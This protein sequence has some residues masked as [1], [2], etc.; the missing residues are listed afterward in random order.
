MKPRDWLFWLV[1]AI[2][3]GTVAAGLAQL[4]VPHVVLDLVGGSTMNDAAYFFAIVGMFMALFG[5]MT[6]QAMF[7]RAS[8]PIILLWASVQKLGASAAVAFGVLHGNFGSL[9]LAISAFDLFSGVVMLAYRGR[10][11][12][13][14]TA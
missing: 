5:G 1:V 3:A 12:R 7:D 10:I 2:A 9:A 11:T 8:H 13:D 6:L 4:C 14:I